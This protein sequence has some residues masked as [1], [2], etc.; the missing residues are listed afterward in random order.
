[1]YLY[2]TRSLRL[3][4]SGILIC[5]GMTILPVKSQAQSYL[6]IEKP[7]K[8]KNFKLKPGSTLQY[9]Q[10]GQQK[11]TTATISRLN[12]SVIFFNT[13]AHI[14]LNSIVAI[15]QGQDMMRILGNFTGLLGVGYISIDVFNNLIN[16]IGPVFNQKTMLISGGL[17]VAALIC[18]KFSTR[19][20]H[21]GKPWRLKVID[22]GN[23]PILDKK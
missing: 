6:I 17:I 11:F 10:A 20:L 13:G 15:K 5:L 23:P 2:P 21:I 9:M 22:L 1:M 3:L 12:D 14:P 8:V 4:L 19:T 18:K 7:G 16:N